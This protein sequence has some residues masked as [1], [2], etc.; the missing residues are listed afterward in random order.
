MF[1]RKTGEIDPAVI[2]YWRD[3]YDLAHIVVSRCR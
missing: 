2:A 3:H 1:D